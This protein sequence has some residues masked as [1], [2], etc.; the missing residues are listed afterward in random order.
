METENIPLARKIIFQTFLSGSIWIFGGVTAEFLDR[1][2]VVT[3]IQASV[4]PNMCPPVHC[5]QWCPTCAPLCIAFSGAQYVPPC[6]YVWCNQAIHIFLYTWHIACIC[7]NRYTY[8]HL[9]PTIS[10]IGAR[11]I[12]LGVLDGSRSFTVGRRACTCWILLDVWMCCEL[13]PAQW[14]CCQAYNP[15]QYRVARWSRWS[16]IQM[17]KNLEQ[18][19]AV[20]LH[21]WKV[22]EDW[23]IFTPKGSLKRDSL[24]VSRA[25]G[26]GKACQYWAVEICWCLK[27]FVSSW[28]PL[29]CRHVVGNA[30]S[31]KNYDLMNYLNHISTQVKSNCASCMVLAWFLLKGFWK[32]TSLDVSRCTSWFQGLFRVIESEA[33]D[34]AARC[35]WLGRAVRIRVDGFRFCR[36]GDRWVFSGR[37][38]Q[39][40][41]DGRLL[42]FKSWHPWV[43]ISF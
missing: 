43:L 2:P 26:L 34:T 35:R 3:F 28:M 42:N 7:K 29:Y 32:E 18:H 39:P 11:K 6:A 23:L 31:P 1:I 19:N 27:C 17:L 13:D 15:E 25:F 33:Q 21:P 4:V 9:N 22:D 38:H 12:L 37:L 36:C 14:H 40:S 5:I 8:K 30:F 16:R 24:F 10:I 41:S 20:K